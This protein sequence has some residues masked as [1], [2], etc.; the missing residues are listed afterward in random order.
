M[1]VH[2]QTLTLF[3]NFKLLQLIV[4]TGVLH[5]FGEAVCICGENCN[6]HKEFRNTY[7][8]HVKLKAYF[9]LF[10]LLQPILLIVYGTIAGLRFGEAARMDES[11]HER[12]QSSLSVWQS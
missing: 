4:L 6:N 1:S 12:V 10:K 7:Y 5:C 2:K 8:V 9:F 11:V 3:I